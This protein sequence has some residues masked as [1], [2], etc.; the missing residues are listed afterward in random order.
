MKLIKIG[1]IVNTHGIK[2][3]L[4]IMSG[5]RYS[6]NE[7]Q[8]TDKVII[9]DKEYEVSSYRKHKSFH[10]ITLKGFNNTNQVLHLVDKPIYIN[11]DQE[12]SEELDMDDLIGMEMVF[13]G[14]VIG[15]VDSIG[16]TPIYQLLVT[17]DQVMVPFIDN[18][19]AEI[20]DQIIL[21]NVEGFFD[22]K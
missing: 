15:V 16:E 3:E 4:R 9:A 17:K 20:D 12:E 2:G 5:G 7:F 8:P 18:F 19:I 6:N 10:M 1:T 22:E 21:Q 14:K 11:G 13:N